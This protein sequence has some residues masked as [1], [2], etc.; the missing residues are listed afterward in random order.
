MSLVNWVVPTAHKNVKHMQHIEEAIGSY[1]ITPTNP[2][3][4][5]DSVMWQVRTSYK[6]L[7][8]MYRK[9]GNRNV[10]KFLK[11]ARELAWT[12]QHSP[13]DMALIGYGM[14]EGN[15][16]GTLAGTV[17]KSLS[18]INSVR[19]PV[20]GALTEH[21]VTRTGSKCDSITLKSSSQ[22]MIEV[23]MDWISRAIPRPTVTSP[24]GSGTPAV[25][26]TAAPWSNLT[27]GTAKLSIG[28]R[29]YPFKDFEVTVQNNLDTGDIDGSDFI[30]YLEPGTKVVEGK[31][32]IVVGKDNLATT[33]NLWDDL[34][35]GTAEAMIFTL[36]STGPKTLSFAQAFIQEMTDEYDS[37]TN[38]VQTQPYSFTCDTVV[39]SA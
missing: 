21:Y 39:A 12:S 19:L 30:E 35:T 1:G 31:F 7:F 23:S 34:E 8:Q 20:S 16:V 17:D 4:V 10:F 29:I 3:P 13:V 14:N 6:T 18:F 2:S 27:G 36:N 32:T 5:D 9:L 25:A 22:G 26:S 38:N 28:G 24:F 33:P 15:N 37:T 11:N